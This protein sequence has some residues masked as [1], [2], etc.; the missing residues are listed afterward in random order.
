MP[1]RNRTRIVV[2]SPGV[3]DVDVGAA[4]IQQTPSE[5]RRCCN[6]TSP[7][8]ALCRTPCAQRKGAREG[9]V[10]GQRQG[11]CSWKRGSASM[12]KKV[13]GAGYVGR[14]RGGR[15][16]F[17][18]GVGARWRG[19]GAEA[20]CRATAG[21]SSDAGL[22]RGAPRGKSAGP[23]AMEQGGNAMEDLC[24]HPPPELKG[25]RVQGG[26]VCALGAGKQGARPWHSLQ[27]RLPWPAIRNG[28]GERL[29]QGAGQPWK[30][31]SSSVPWRRARRHG[32]LEPL[33]TYRN[34][35][36]RRWRKMERG[37]GFLLLE[38]QERGGK[39]IWEQRSGHGRSSAC[40]RRWAPCSSRGEEGR[41]CRASEKKTGRR[42]CGG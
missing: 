10:R 29:G 16:V 13:P 3:N 15:L 9:D 35:V 21:R 41:C 11:C 20:L 23:D 5:R 34:R 2:V 28:G 40:R 36:K 12:G 17:H 30:G 14:T 24:E 4:Q 1:M 32:S 38:V 39:P 42:G 31:G 18:G 7:S 8:Q 33:R 26:G 25:R 19:A 22:H 37:A 6:N 27:Q